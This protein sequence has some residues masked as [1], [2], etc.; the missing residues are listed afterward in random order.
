MIV[1]PLHQA[2]LRAASASGR[3]WAAIMKGKITI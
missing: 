1:F 3:I 2:P